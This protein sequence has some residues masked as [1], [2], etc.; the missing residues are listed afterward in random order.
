MAFKEAA[1]EKV[2][3]TIKERVRI[4]KVSPDAGMD[5]RSLLERSREKYNQQMG[6]YPT[7][8]C[9]DW[10]GS[11]ADIGGGGKSTS[12]RA[13]SWE[14]AASGCVSFADIHQV[15]TLVLA[16]A[17]NDSQLKR[18]LSIQDI[19]ISKGIAKNMVAAIGITN[20]MDQAGVKAAVSGQRDMPTSMFLEDQF[21]CTCKA[22]KGEGQNIA[23]RRDF[24]YQRFVARPRT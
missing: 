17:V 21:F 11:M 24:R 20:S 6:R 8:V 16:Q 19:G 7:W 23:V 4:F 18:V 15:P 2:L 5:A 9:L 3:N 1:V 12:E 13:M 10:L 14:L 22:R